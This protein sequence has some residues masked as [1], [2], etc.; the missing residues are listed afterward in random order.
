MANYLY[1]GIELPELP[2]W[3][4]D[5]YPYVL[6]TRVIASDTYWLDFSAYTVI[7]HIGTTNGRPS[8]DFANSYVRYKMVDGVW[9]EVEIDSAIMASYLTNTD[10]S[11]RIDVVWCNTDILNKDG[12]VYLAASDPVPVLPDLLPVTPYLPINGAW[13]KY[14]FYKQVGNSWVKQPQGAVEVEGGAWS[15]LS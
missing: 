7:P 4:N 1:N 6:I 15:A 9:T 12:S 2:E 13:V 8:I 11:A 14:G 3:G 5:E 10:G